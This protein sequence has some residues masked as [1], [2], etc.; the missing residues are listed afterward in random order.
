[1]YDNKSLDFTEVNYDDIS[2]NWSQVGY[3]GITGAV[4][5]PSMLSTVTNTQKG[6]FRYSNEA[7]KKLQKQQYDTKS[8][9]K[10]QKL[11]PRIDAH[12]SNQWNHLKFQV[13]NKA[14]TEV[15]SKPYNDGENTNE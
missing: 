14:I 10:F 2:I 12:K 5:A 1:M 6:S 11:Q 4:L 3:S 7:W 8:S 13:V 15:G 9:S